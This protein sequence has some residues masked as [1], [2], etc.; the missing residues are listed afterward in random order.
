MRPRIDAAA[1]GLSRVVELLDRLMLGAVALG[2]LTLAGQLILDLVADFVGR[3][4]HDTPHMVG[5]LMF[6]LIVME[7]FRQTVRQI[8]QDPFSFKPFLA[9]GVIA[10][11][12]GMLVV[13]MRAGIGNLDWTTGAQTIVAF[14]LVVL[15]LIIAYSLCHKFESPPRS[16]S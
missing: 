5:E 4:V 16:E 14:A 8:R 12:R 15:A 11:V 2:T 3:E 10:S 6:V 7:L 9:I 1:K 13:Q